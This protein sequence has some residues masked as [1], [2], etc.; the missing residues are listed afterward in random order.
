MPPVGFRLTHLYYFDLLIRLL[1]VCWLLSVLADRGGTADVQAV[2]NAGGKRVALEAR[3]F[4]RHADR[5]IELLPVCP[6]F[7]LD[8]IIHEA[9]FQ[10]VCCR[11]HGDG[12]LEL[13]LDNAQNTNH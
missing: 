10:A 6:I 4:C 2:M 12:S 3:R 13:V 9:L 1:T 8:A 11:Y 5:V 7:G